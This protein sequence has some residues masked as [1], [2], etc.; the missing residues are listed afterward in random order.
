MSYLKCYQVLGLSPGA[1]LRQVHRSY[2]RLVLLHH[3]DRTAGD[4]ASLAAFCEATEAYAMLK[5]AF[6]LREVSKFAGPCPKCERIKELFRGLDGRKYC[7]DCLLTKGRKYLPLPTYEQMRCIGVIGLQSLAVYCTVVSAVLE[8]W[9]HAAFG[10]GFVFLALGW[11]A[12]DLY[13]A[14]VIE[15]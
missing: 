15:R 2:K 7:A 11:L 14:D 6:A 10:M 12:F 4:A 3:P 13:R 8:S 5:R 1:T 9:Q